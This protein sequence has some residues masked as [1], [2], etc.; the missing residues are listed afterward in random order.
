MPYGIVTIRS[1]AFEECISLASMTIPASVITIMGNAF[2]ECR[3]LTRLDLPGSLTT[4]G[5]YAFAGCAALTDLALPAGLLSM[6]EGAFGGLSSLKDVTIPASV[7]SLPR[8]A[9]IECSSLANVTLQSGITSIGDVA[10]GFCPALQNV[11]L[12]ATIGTLGMGVFYQCTSLQSIGL[13]QTITSIDNDTFFGC[14]SLIEISLPANVSTIGERAFFNC[15][16]LRS[17]AMPQGLA[18]INSAAFSGCSLLENITLPS[19]IMVI[20]DNALGK[21]AMLNSISFLGT[22]PPSS[23]SISWIAETGPG[24]QGH[25]YRASSFPLPGADLMGLPMGVYLTIIPDSPT[26][27]NVS[28]GRESVLLTW[29]APAYDGDGAIQSYRIYRSGSLDGDYALLASLND[30]SYDDK[31]VSGGRTY[32]YRLTAVN[33]AGESVMTQGF[34]ATAIAAADDIEVAAAVAVSSGIAIAAAAIA[35]QATAGASGAAPGTFAA[36]WQKF[37]LVIKKMT[38]FLYGYAEDRA[39]DYVFD[40]VNK[41]EPERGVPVYREGFLSAFSLRELGVIAFASVVMGLTFLIAKRMQVLDLQNLLVFIVVAGF[42]LTLHDMAHRYVAWKHKTTSEYQVWWLG[43]LI[44]FFTAGLFGVVYATPS[45]LRLD[46]KAPLTKRQK[47]LIHGAG[48]LMSFTVFLAFALL[49]P[50]GSWALKIGILGCSMNLL[51][52]VYTMMPFDPMDGKKV[53]DWNRWLWLAAF[54][55]LLVLYFALTIYVF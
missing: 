51:V 18:A 20:G 31:N 12:P 38:D 48:P 43:S 39:T 53:F 50:M 52:A 28:G 16:S 1:S 7:G 13:P 34:G 27:V 49:I 11:T 42:A 55:P 9:F 54:L 44:M 23:I 26:E 40:K 24:L 2:R 35:S 17:I 37:L 19:N 14:S 5:D 8:A 30:T 45:R 41:V 15:T 46:K 47:A 36:W 4:I 29:T 22:A 3:G 10:F 25:A 21:C 33:A 6:G 32:W